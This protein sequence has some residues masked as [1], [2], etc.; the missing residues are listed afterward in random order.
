[1]KE[2]FIRRYRSDTSGPADRRTLIRINDEGI[3]TFADNHA[4]AV[5]GYDASEL[6]GR[7]VH[8]ILAARQDDPFA[9][10]NRHRIESGEPV[11]ITFRH[12]EG[13]FFTACLS[14]R[15]TMRDS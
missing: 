2:F 10:A 5:L 14:L 1:M 4:D 8:S 12:K 7:P 11:M 9:P 6:E 13:F 3:I 15:M